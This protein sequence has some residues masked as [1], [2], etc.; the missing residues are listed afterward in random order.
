MVFINRGVLHPLYPVGKDVWG[1][2]FGNSCN[3]ANCSR[4][5]LKNVTV[6]WILKKIYPI[7]WD[8]EGLLL[9]TQEPATCS[10]PEPDEF[11]PL[12]PTILL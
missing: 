5:L 8:L 2:C 3:V 4:A 7:L 10:R 9:C 1:Y 6:L 12:P 11:T